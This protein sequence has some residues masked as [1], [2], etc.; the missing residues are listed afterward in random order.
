[1]DT[2][3]SSTDNRSYKAIKDNTMSDTYLSN[4]MP[5]TR[6]IKKVFGSNSTQL[7]KRYRLFV[8]KVVSIATT[9]N[10]INRDLYNCTIQ[11][12]C[13]LVNINYPPISEFKILV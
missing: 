4:T 5:Q 11:T 2:D 3:R 1:M 7:H 10:L 12:R 9:Y 6:L 8:F 13:Y